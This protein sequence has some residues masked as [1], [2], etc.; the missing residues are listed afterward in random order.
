MNA[1]DPNVERRYANWC[2]TL[3]AL[4][5]AMTGILFS[6]LT[7]HYGWHHPAIGPASL[8]L[9]Q[10]VSFI[11]A[12][13]WFEFRQREARARGKWAGFV[14]PGLLPHVAAMGGF[15]ALMFVVLYAFGY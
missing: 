8:T 2:G 7:W 1:A 6:S 14:P 3:G 13:P 10:F 15:Y 11:A 5:G 12:Y 9:P 4:V